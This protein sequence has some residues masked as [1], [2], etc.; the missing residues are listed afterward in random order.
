MKTFVCHFFLFTVLFFS[1]LIA[2]FE[3]EVNMKTTHNV[4][5]TKKE[6][7]VVMYIKNDMLAFKMDDEQGGGRNTRIVYRADSNV[8]LIIDDEKKTVVTMSIKSLEDMG[9][10][11]A[12]KE[13]KI[14]VRKA[15]KSQTILGYQCEGWLV[16]SEHQVRE[17]YGTS[18]LGNVYEKFMMTFGKLRRDKT[19]EWQKQLS[20]LKIFP[21]KITTT[22]D[23]NITSIDEV[24]KIENKKLLASM[25]EAPK[26]YSTQSLDAQLGGAMQKMQ[27]E[28]KKYQKSG[29]LTPEMQKMI[30]QNM[31]K[32][33]EHDE[34]KEDSTDEDDDND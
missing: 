12:G 17:I 16:E 7:L 10:A 4:G 2:Q 1:P 29:T 9:K 34:E 3:G 5:E 24:T 6:N 8:I 30:E 28:M 23:G 32:M 11:M 18:K 22:R 21:L 26:D 14:N 27:E 13:E 19:E 20:K 25:F 33:E 31:K 15:G